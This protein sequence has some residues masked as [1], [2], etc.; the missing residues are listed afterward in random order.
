MIEV[1]AWKIAA[2]VAWRMRACQGGRHVLNRACTCRKRKWVRET[3]QHLS[4]DI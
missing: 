4:L 2:S 3:P 1:L